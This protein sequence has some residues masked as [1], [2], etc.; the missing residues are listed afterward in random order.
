MVDLCFLNSTRIGRVSDIEQVTRANIPLIET[1]SD[2][3]KEWW[4]FVE[5]DD[6]ALE[7]TGEF[8]Y[9]W[10]LKLLNSN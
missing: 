3:D 4:G 6:V 8:Q 2:E 9:Y 5:N 7:I 1:A 10:S